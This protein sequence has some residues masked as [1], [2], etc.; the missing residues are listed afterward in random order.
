MR[1]IL[2]IVLAFTVSCASTKGIKTNH[3]GTYLTDDKQASIKLSADS[4]FTYNYLSHISGGV[5]C[6][7][8]Y[9]IIDNTIVFK[10]TYPESSDSLGFP[11]WSFKL[12]DTVEIG[13]LKKDT[14]LFKKQI[15]LKI[16]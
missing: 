15:F 11:L 13:F 3:L 8:R 9:K 5:M 4:T 16:N 2:F 1:F 7:G 12:C 10:S 14:I 6:F